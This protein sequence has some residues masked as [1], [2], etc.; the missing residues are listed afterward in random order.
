MSEHKKLVAEGSPLLP[1]ILTAIG[2]IVLALVFAES[3]LE[4]TGQPFTFLDVAHKSGLLTGYQVATQPN[5]GIW[6]L[7]GWIGS[8]CFVIMMLYSMRKHFKFM[9]N[10]GPI[11]YWLDIH[12]FLG[13]VGTL[14]VTAH[15]TYKFGG[16]VALSYWS[17]VLVAVS[18]F[19]G[20]YLYVQIPRSISGQEL[21]MDEINEIMDDITLEIEKFAKGQYD[22]QH[23]FERIAGPKPDRQLSAFGALM[24]LFTTDIKNMATMYGI[25]RGL[26][27]NRRI[28][29]HVRNRIFK[30]IR[31][32][33]RLVRSIEFLEAS[34]KL[35]HYWHVFHKPFAIIMF[36]VMFLHVG[37]Y[38]VF[39]I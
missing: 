17:A 13:I 2:I 24:A 6:H 26:K 11:R 10:V 35:L 34:H 4:L 25:W 30:L 1:L 8:A 36:I 12:M 39:R 32:K 18:G 27:A 33:G 28:P 20:R 16:I 15:S 38:Y 9:Q 14:L 3:Y 22:V 31:E 5:R 21:K 19:L 23:Y 37:V 7:V 29:D